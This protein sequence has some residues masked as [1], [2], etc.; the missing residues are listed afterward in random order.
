MRPLEHWMRLRAMAIIVCLWL[1]GGSGMA[2]QKGGTAKAR[3]GKARAAAAK[4][5]SDAALV[6][7]S[8]LQANADGTAPAGVAGWN[9]T[10]HSKKTGKW[11]SYHAGPSGLEAVD[12]PAGFTQAVPQEFID[13]DKV[14]PEVSKHGFKMSGA[15]LLQLNV[16]YDRNVKPGFY[17]CAT[18]ETDITPQLEVKSWCVD[19]KTGKFVARLAGGAMTPEAAKPKGGGTF[20]V[21]LSKCG[22]FAAA[23]AAG[24]LGVPAAH[25]KAAAEKVSDSE[26]KCT[27]AAGGGKA[28][29]FTISSA[30]SVKEAEARIEQYRKTLDDEYTEL[31]L[32]KDA[33]GIWSNATSTLTVR[34]GNVIVRTLQPAEKVKQAKLA[35]SVVGKF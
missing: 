33:E 5:Q 35:D 25:V 4:W 26:W 13:S 27:F 14:L 1:P 10:F 2:A 17:W 23:D 19:P 3:L 7:V 15:T 20:A 16:V 11:I 12:L 8:A 29:V 32:N 24:H 6:T 18:G 28:L 9:F 21:D 31:T 30:A 22:G 34:R